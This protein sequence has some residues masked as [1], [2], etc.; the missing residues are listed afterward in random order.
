MLNEFPIF[1]TN[2]SNLFLSPVATPI[3]KKSI[4]NI[5]IRGKN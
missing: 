2:I 4:S 5:M 3:I 1:Q